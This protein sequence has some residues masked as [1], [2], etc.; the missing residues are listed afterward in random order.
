MRFENLTEIIPSNVIPEDNKKSYLKKQNEV[1]SREN[2]LLKKIIR[3][4]NIKSEIKK[5]IN[6]G[7]EDIDLSS[8][9]DGPFEDITLK[10]SFGTS[11]K[12]ILRTSGTM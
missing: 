1:I 3:K 12:G 5:L 9:E 4:E 6:F 8:E 2:K 11:D 10:G 7:V